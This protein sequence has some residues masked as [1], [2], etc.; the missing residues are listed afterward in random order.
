[1]ASLADLRVEYSKAALD[2]DHSDADPLRQFTRWWDEAQAAQVREANAMTLATAAA[3]GRPGARTV[4]LKGYDENGFVFFTNYKS[5]KGT[6]L[7]D[8]PRA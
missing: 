5:R 6:E 8:N 7:A 3:D 4:L 2:E 1:M